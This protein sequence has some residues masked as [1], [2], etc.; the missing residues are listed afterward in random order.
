MDV[1]TDIRGKIRQC[2]YDL[3]MAKGYA[4]LSFGYVDGLM[5]DK[6]A[7]DEPLSTRYS[8]DVEPCRGMFFCDGIMAVSIESFHEPGR[9]GDQGIEIWGKVALFDAGTLEVLYEHYIRRTL[10]VT[11]PGSRE[12]Y[13]ARAVKDFTRDLLNYLPD[14][15]GRSKLDSAP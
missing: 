4:P 6:G 2:L 11:D 7:Y 10:F 3:M 5:R 13:L 1:D 12:A 8:W 15:P 14:K 9:P